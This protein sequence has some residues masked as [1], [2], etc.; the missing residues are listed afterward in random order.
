MTVHFDEEVDTHGIELLDFDYVP[1]CEYIREEPL[2]D[3]PAEWIVTMACC[4]SQHLFCDDHF[5]AVLEILN[6][7]CWLEHFAKFGGCGKT[8]KSPFLSAERLDKR[9]SK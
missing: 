5:N 2:C 4:G 3:Y 7:G 8:T 9:V 6:G 1:P